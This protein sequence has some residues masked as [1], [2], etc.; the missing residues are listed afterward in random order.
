M[1]DASHAIPESPPAN[2]RSVALFRRNVPVQAR[3]QAIAR[4]FKPKA[5]E[6]Y[7]DANG[8][9]AVITCWLARGGGTWFSHAPDAVAA[10]SRRA[11]I[12]AAVPL[13]HGWPLP[14]EDKTFDAIVATDFPLR[15]DSPDDFIA[16]CHRVLKPSGRLLVDLPHAKRFGLLGPRGR[17][18]A[19]DPAGAYSQKELFNLLKDGF[20]VLETHTYCRFFLRLAES[21]TLRATARAR[22]RDA[23]VARLYAIAYPFFLVAM[24]LDVLLFPT[25]GYRIVALAKRH[26]WRPRKTPV[27]ADGR[28]MPEAVLSTVGR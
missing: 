5:H 7:L 3:I 21:I 8:A 11:L 26:S 1:P 10:E 22:D 24:Q 12:P 16:E 9:E 15:I 13:T 4:F 2:D 17:A 18:R 28:S 20:D 27:L 14:F 6:T 23:A 19:A 25:R